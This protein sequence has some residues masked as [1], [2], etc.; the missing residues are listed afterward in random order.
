[1]RH[2]LISILIFVSIAL[3]FFAGFSNHSSYHQTL[4]F[5]PGTQPGSVVEV[6]SV[7]NCKTCH[8][9]A[10]L[11]RPVSTFN[12]WS[13][14]PMAHAARD[15]IFFAALAVTNKYE[16]SVG[17]FCIRCHSPTGWLI[18]HS[19]DPM[20]KNLVGTDFDGIQCDF[21]HRAGNPLQPDS[22]IP[23]LTF[24]VPGIGNA[25]NV[26]QQSKLPKR[27]P[28]ADTN[29]YHPTRQE[30]FQKTSDMCG[31]CHDISNPYYAEDRIHQQPHEYSPLERTYSEWLMSNY[32]AMGDSGTCQSCHMQTTG[33]YGAIIGSPY[34]TDLRQHDLTGGNTFLP[35]ILPEFWSNL[36]VD[37]LQAGKQRALSTLRRAAELDLTIERFNDSIIASVRITNLTGHKLPTGYP[38]GRRMWLNIIA[39]DATNDTIFQSGK[40]DTA[41]AILQHDDQLKIY[42]SHHG[43]KDSTAA[44]YNLAAGGSFHFALNDTILFDNRIPPRGFTNSGFASRLAEPRDYSYADSQYWDETRYLLPSNATHITANLYYQTISKEY[45]EF[46][47]DENIDNEY[48]WNNWGEKLYNAWAVN[49]KSVPV[50]MN[51]V[52]TTITGTDKQFSAPVTFELLQNY[53]NPFNPVTNFRFSIS[54]FRFVSLTI[55]DIIGNEIVTLVNEKKSPGLHNVNWDASQ[56]PSGIYIARVSSEGV[57][58]TIKILLLK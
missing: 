18:G 9:S 58:R 34:R 42:E 14:S 16:P 15:P 39:L 11:S 41:T 4:I 26:F 12:D 47:R 19:L 3:L 30:P 33:G 24:P 35:D 21:C 43:L 27:G 13:G 37:A 46:L 52:T 44:R 51:T 28:Y 38:E 25:M 31:V 40:Y 50:L 49:G 36:N 22:S 48:D 29:N 53:P 56:Q 17:E 20:G 57:Q 6:D 5:L 8:H 32:P 2:T 45:I 1:M 54:E 23:P 10:S 55:Y 7:Q